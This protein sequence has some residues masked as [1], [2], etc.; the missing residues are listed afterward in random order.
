MNYYDKDSVGWPSDSFPTLNMDHIDGPLLTLRNGK[1]HWLTLLERIQIF[2]NLVD[3]EFLER[4]HW[5][6]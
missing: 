1:L 2:L 6:D 3:A 5:N 4:K